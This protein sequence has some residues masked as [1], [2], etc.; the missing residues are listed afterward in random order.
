MSVAGLQPGDKEKSEDASASNSTLSSGI[1]SG[2]SVKSAE[3]DALSVG[4]GTVGLG[5]ILSLS[6]KG[7]WMLLEQALRTLDRGNPD[8]SQ[9]EEVRHWINTIHVCCFYL[10]LFTCTNSGNLGKS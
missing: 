10:K 4:S 8:V 1:G 3:L 9:K 5:K 7:E 2:A 6:L